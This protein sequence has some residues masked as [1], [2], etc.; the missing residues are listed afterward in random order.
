KCLAKDPD[1]RW[2][3]AG[4]LADE[5]RWI[6]EPGSVSVPQTSQSAPWKYAAWVLGGIAAVALCIAAVLWF[7]AAD[8][9][10][11]AMLFHAAVPFA[12]NDVA[13]SPDGN[14]AALVAYSDSGNN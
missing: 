10:A 14:S 7:K 5:L 6:S 8:A 9:E 13:V 12:V 1:E 2:Q 4:D 3:T 11:P